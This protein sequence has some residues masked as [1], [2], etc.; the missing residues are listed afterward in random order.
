[1]ADSMV[2]D[3]GLADFCRMKQTLEEHEMPSPTSSRKREPQMCGAQVDPCT[4][5]RPTWSALRNRKT[6]R[7]VVPEIQTMEKIVEMA[8]VQIQEVIRQL[9]MKR[10]EKSGC[11]E[12]ASQ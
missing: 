4:T 11:Y 3:M 10:Q 7:Q 6:V 9:P 1:M 12:T 8:E 5:T 2:E